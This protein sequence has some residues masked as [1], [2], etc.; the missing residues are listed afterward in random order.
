MI[1]DIF[2][3]TPVVDLGVER[4]EF[5]VIGDIYEDTDEDTGVSKREL[6][7]AKGVLGTTFCS[8][9]T[10]TSNTGT[11]NTGISTSEELLFDKGVLGRK[12]GSIFNTSYTGISTRLGELLTSVVGNKLLLLLVDGH[13]LFEVD[14]FSG[15]GLQ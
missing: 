5:V 8:T 14:T 11:S 9:S 7:F 10:G 15:D 3:G 13:N 6:L 12:V 2:F 4:G 1:V